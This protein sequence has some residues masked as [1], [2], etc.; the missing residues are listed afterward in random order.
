[1]R[2]KFEVA[3]IAIC[4][5]LFLILCPIFLY[6]L[7]ATQIE[8]L[9]RKGISLIEENQKKEIASNIHD[10]L[11]QS[12]VISKMRITE[13]EKKWIKYQVV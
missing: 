1:M 13:L 10:H 9:K 6:T 7:L 2:I 8:N 5:F 11:S 3:S 4:T 12:L